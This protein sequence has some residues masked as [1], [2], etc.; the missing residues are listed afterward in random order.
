ME[1]LNGFS[2]QNQLDLL[3]HIVQPALVIH[4]GLDQITP[5]AAGRY[6]AARLPHGDFFELPG[7]GHAPFLSRP[8]EVVDR[9]LEFC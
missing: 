5:L 2:E 4:G 1:L 3:S 7:V 8:Q 9:I 6:L